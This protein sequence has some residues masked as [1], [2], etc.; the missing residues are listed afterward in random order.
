MEKKEII[1]MN[2]NVALYTRVSTEDQ[3]KYIPLRY[4]EKILNLLLSAKILRYSRFIK[5]MV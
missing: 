1:N 2:H 4:S 5:T 3:I